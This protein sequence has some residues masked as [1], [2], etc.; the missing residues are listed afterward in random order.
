MAVLQAHTALIRISTLERKLLQEDRWNDSR[1][2]RVRG[3]W[4]AACWSGCS[5][6]GRASGKDHPQPVRTCTAKYT[7][8]S[9]SETKNSRPCSCFCCSPILL[10]WLC[11][12]SSMLALTAAIARNISM[13]GEKSAAAP[14]HCTGY[15][16][17]LQG[18]KMALSAPWKET[19]LCLGGAGLSAPLRA[20]PPRYSVHDGT[21][22]TCH[23]TLWTIL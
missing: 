6:R 19:S 4:V 1:G 15:Q 18:S 7:S 17:S 9:T 3:P 14:C 10:C 21:P 12:N 22:D 5:P 16:D 13:F 8:T 23:W 2:T 11:L 20:N